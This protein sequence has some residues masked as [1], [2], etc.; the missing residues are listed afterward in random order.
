M[1]N[2]ITSSYFYQY[3]QC[4]YWPYQEMHGDPSRKKPADP[5]LQKTMGESLE[6]EKSVMGQMEYLQPDYPL[7]DY[8]QGLQITWELMRSGVDLIGHGVLLSGDFLG[9]PDLLEKMQ[10]PSRLG[11]YHYRPVEVKA[12][13]M[14]K[15]S[16]L[17]QVLYYSNLLETL[18]GQLPD[19]AGIILRDKGHRT[20]PV[21]KEMPI[22]QAALEDI[23]AMRNGEEKIPHISSH[24]KSCAWEELCREVAHQREDLSLVSRLPKQLKLE[25]IALGIKT[26]SQ[27]AGLS[28][29]RIRSLRALGVKVPW[30]LRLQALA[31]TEKRVIEIGSPQLPK[32][33]VEVFFDIEGEQK[34]GV[35]YLL[36]T[37]VRRP[38]SEEH[39]S[40]VA[41]RPEEEGRI[42]HEFLRLM[43]GLEDFVV[44]HY[45]TYELITLA[46]LK[47]KY[48]GSE[49]IYQRVVDN[50]VDLFKMIK[51]TVI[52]PTLSYSLKEIARWLGFHWSNR[53][54]NAPQSML[55]YALW[56]ETGERRYLD[57]SIEYN[58]DDCEAT[59]VVKD[60][61]VTVGGS[62]SHNGLRE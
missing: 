1:N 19:T 37:L 31:L 32:R 3:A 33:S 14:M 52:L 13:R 30:N 61:L 45:H 2:L 21:P 7:G 35:A 39:H 59:K 55:W 6:F 38:G 41:D 27:L 57:W 46:R 60:W 58:R 25:L 44:Y 47:E 8:S 43:A 17:L 49:D 24:C 26:V 53:Q 34:H 5:F 40:F 36:G 12:G 29:Q 23:E 28:C 10:G 54:A 20:I 9:V 51:D 11:D 48:G 56:L 42:W 16:Y 62:R 22:F 4:H 18:Q 15:K 50:M